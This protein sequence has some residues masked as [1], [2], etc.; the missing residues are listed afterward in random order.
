[1]LLRYYT[2]SN[3][4][5]AGRYAEDPPCDRNALQRPLYELGG[6][7]DKEKRYKVEQWLFV[8]NLIEN[9]GATPTFVPINGSKPTIID[10]TVVNGWAKNMI[11][12]WEVNNRVPTFLDHIKLEFHINRT[13]T[14]KTNMARAI[15]T[16]QT[17]KSVCTKETLVLWGPSSSPNTGEKK[18]W[19]L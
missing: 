4:T 15:R 19:K 10:L 3:Y 1:M 16:G 12:N 18:A 13:Y 17:I 7:E 6:G 14:T 8:K 9:V 11:P 5:G 2:T